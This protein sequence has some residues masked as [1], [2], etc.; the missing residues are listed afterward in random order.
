MSQVVTGEAV[1]L[2][3]RIARLGSRLVAALLDGIVQF[4]LLMGG[5]FVVGSIAYDGGTAAALSVVLFVGTLVGYPVA[6]ETLWRGRTPGKAAMGLRVVR[7][8]GGPIRFRHAFA[9]GLLN[10]VE[11]PGITM[12]IGA[13]VTSLVSLRAKRLGDLVAGTIVLQERV[14]TRV[15]PFVAMPPPLAGW[16][17][18]LDLSRLPDDLALRVRD[19]LGR[20]GQLNPQARESIGRTLV[21][22]V[23]D[24]VAAPP[25]QGTPGWAYLAAVLA[26]RRR[27]EE[28]RLG[29]DPRVGWSSAGPSGWAARPPT[30][31]WGVPPPTTPWSASAPPTGTTPPTGVAPPTGSP[32][33]DP[34]PPPVGPPPQPVTGPAPVP[35]SEPPPEPG[36]FALPG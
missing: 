28:A 13:V 8:D 32:P 18:T 9:R 17:A 16:A 33:A 29:V 24:A 6:F 7:D 3:L 25:P 1:A 14:P 10:L 36:P 2:D 15:T 31:G 4:A 21:A 30:P 26:E 12:G 5:I 34:G 22:A 27:R 11:R 23:A 19:F 35:P 20:A